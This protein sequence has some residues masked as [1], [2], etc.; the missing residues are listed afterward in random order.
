MIQDFLRGESQ[1]RIDL[2]HV[3]EEMEAFRRDGDSPIRD[4]ALDAVGHPV[5]LWVAGMRSFVGSVAC[6]HAEE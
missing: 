4:E 2:Q 5:E 1:S 3:L 6:D